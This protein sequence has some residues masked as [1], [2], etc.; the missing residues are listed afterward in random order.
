VSIWCWS[1]WL[2]LKIWLVTL[3][4]FGVHLV[5]IWCWSWWLLLKPKLGGFTEIWCSFGVHLVLELVA[6]IKNLVA[7]PKFGVHLVS[8]WCWSWWLLLKPK[9][10]D[11]T[12]I[13]CSYGVGVH[14][15]VGS[16]CL[17]HKMLNV[18]VSVF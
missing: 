7:L 15:G 5:S 12:E 14:V 6:F 4:K 16:W 11:F 1:W 10:G 9:L 18:S 8:I 2:L 13:W 17:L 3:P